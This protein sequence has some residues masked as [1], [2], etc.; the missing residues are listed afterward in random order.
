MP[1]CDWRYTR[2]TGHRPCASQENWRGV[3]ELLRT[4]YSKSAR[5]DLGYCFIYDALSDQP[6]ISLDDGTELGGYYSVEAVK[7]L[8][9]YQLA[10][11]HPTERNPHWLTELGKGWAMDIIERKLV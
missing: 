5:P 4:A 6:T 11:P 8:Y 10:V 7:E 2:Q 9:G 1:G 3:K